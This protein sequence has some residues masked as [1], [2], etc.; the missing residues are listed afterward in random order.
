MNYKKQKTTKFKWMILVSTKSRANGALDHSFF[1][2]PRHTYVVFARYET[3]KL[4]AKKTT[5]N[6]E[7]VVVIMH[8]FDHFFSFLSTLIFFFLLF[9]KL[10][11]NC[12]QHQN[13][14]HYSTI[15]NIFSYLNRKK[16]RSN[17]KVKKPNGNETQQNI[18]E[19]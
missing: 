3:W 10:F 8:I 19:T 5:Q 11:L 16:T 14:D 17:S 1:S 9:V 6:Q 13:Y 7:V 4:K 18:R 12:F 15:F 2:K